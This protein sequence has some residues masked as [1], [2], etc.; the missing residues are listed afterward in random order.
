MTFWPSTNDV[1]YRNDNHMFRSPH[2]FAAILERHRSAVKVGV[3]GF[4]DEVQFYTDVID[5]M[6]GW[7]NR[8]VAA[9]SNPAVRGG[10]PPKAQVSSGS[11]ALWGLL[12][13]YGYLM[14]AISYLGAEQTLCTV[15]HSIIC[16]SHRETFY[17]ANFSFAGEALFRLYRQSYV[18]DRL[19][20][21]FAPD[22]LTGSWTTAAH[23]TL[24][25]ELSA[26]RQE[27]LADMDYVGMSTD[28]ALC[29]FTRKNETRFDEIEAL[30]VREVDLLVEEILSTFTTLATEPTRDVMISGSVLA[31]TLAYII[32]VH[33]LRFACLQYSNARI[34]RER[35]LNQAKFKETSQQLDQLLLHDPH[36]DGVLLTN[37]I[38]NNHHRQRVQQPNDFVA[39]KVA[40]V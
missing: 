29:S 15:F 37:D 12:Q 24:F 4:W 36:S 40:S 9:E 35:K 14:G 39:L 19:D 26:C 16:F 32:G 27:I 28:P 20:R 25:P 21:R 2:L 7:L 22:Q 31:V 13:S 1:Q 3:A 5:E 18:G 10:A 8:E 23:R 6:L 30:S 17:Y 33:A 11:P 38:G 34:K